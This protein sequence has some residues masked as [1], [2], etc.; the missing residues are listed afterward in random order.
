MSSEPLDP[1]SAAADLRGDETF[2]G[3][4]ARVLDF[5]RFAMS[6]LRM[7]NTRGYLAEFLVARAL[8]L[9][10]VRRV[11]WEAYDLLF[12]GI[13]V[14]VMS[15]A[16]L[17]AWPQERHSRLSFGGLRTGPRGSRTLNA[18]VYVFC[19]QTSVRHS[20]YD[21]LD[22][23]EWTFHVVSRKA[24]DAAAGDSIGLGG[25]EKASGGATPWAGLADAV[26]EA[27]PGSPER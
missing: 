25:V 13:S 24:L 22:L 11:E 5:W 12:E 18:D 23:A 6:D 2:V 9:Q 21:P 19:T 10:D 15:S 8:G 4:D 7:N 26:R 3:I 16:L 27:H 17:Q 1:P 14:E 20:E